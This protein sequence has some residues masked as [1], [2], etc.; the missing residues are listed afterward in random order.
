MKELELLQEILAGARTAF[1]FGK[2][3]IATQVRTLI[4]RDVD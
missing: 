4:E 1:V 3:D 2:G